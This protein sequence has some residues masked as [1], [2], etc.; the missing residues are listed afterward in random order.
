MSYLITF[1]SNEKPTAVCSECPYQFFSSDKEEVGRCGC[2]LKDWEDNLIPEEHD[3]DEPWEGCPVTEAFE[4]MK[5]EDAGAFIEHREDGD[6]ASMSLETIEFLRKWLYEHPGEDYVLKTID[7]YTDEAL[8]EM[9]DLH[10]TKHKE[11]L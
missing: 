10:F 1:R 3:P 4:G 7:E 9:A 8:D 11:E 6:V 2:C 5:P